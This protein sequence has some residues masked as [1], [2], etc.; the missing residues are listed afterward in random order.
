MTDKTAFTQHNNNQA[1]INNVNTAQHQHAKGSA[2][3]ELVRQYNE[4]SSIQQETQGKVIR[5]QTMRSGAEQRLAQLLT[6]AKERFGVNSVEELRELYQANLAHNQK[7]IPEAYSKAVEIKQRVLQ[8][9]S[10]IN[11]Q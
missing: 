5:F 9:E 3:V 10:S 4:I 2:E 8:I 6:E 7:V 1:P 11:P